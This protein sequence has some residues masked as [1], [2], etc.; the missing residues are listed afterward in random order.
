MTYPFERFIN[1]TKKQEEIARSIRRSR[2]EEGWSNKPSLTALEAVPT[3]FHEFVKQN[4]YQFSTAYMDSLGLD[5]KISPPRLLVLEKGGTRKISEGEINGGFYTTY[6]RFIAVDSSHSKA[7][8]ASAVAHEYFHSLG[9]S[10]FYIDGEES[11]FKISPYRSG[12]SMNDPKNKDRQ[13]FVVAEEALA[14]DFAES[15]L[16]YAAGFDEDIAT[17]V[18][19]RDVVVDFFSNSRVFKEGYPTE[20][21]D[22]FIAHLEQLRALTDAEDVV[23]VLRDPARDD[24][25]KI[26]YA[27]AYLKQRMGEYTEHRKERLA[28]RIKLE[29]YITE[30]VSCS[31]KSITPAEVR[32][33]FYR[34]HFTGEYL[35]L[36]RVV[37]SSLGPGSFRAMAEDLSSV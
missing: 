8:F 16:K 7:V 1:G 30:I 25:Y 18:E 20:K 27:F 34:A 28:E 13:Y 9:Y 21:Y 26:G 22:G 17:E 23:R 6:G 14:A 12:V 35:P 10:S 32:N 24:G 15:Y 31:S 33:L 4:V 5:E 29:A 2:Y 3:A 11:D 37:E 36:A 19:S